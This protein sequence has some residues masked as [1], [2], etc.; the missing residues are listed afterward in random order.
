MSSQPVDKDGLRTKPQTARCVNAKNLTNHRW[1]WHEERDGISVTHECGGCS[2]IQSAFIPLDKLEE[3]VH[4]AKSIP[5][6][7]KR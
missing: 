4:I 7:G 5:K 3:Y 2:R 6:R 1:R